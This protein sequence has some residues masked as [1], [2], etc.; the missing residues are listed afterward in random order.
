[1]K[2]NKKTNLLGK[3]TIKTYLFQKNGRMYLIAMMNFLVLN[4]MATTSGLIRLYLEKE[5]RII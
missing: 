2:S 5:K 4:L 3:N 1:M